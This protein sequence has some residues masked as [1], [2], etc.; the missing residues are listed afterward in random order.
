VLP[1]SKRPYRNQEASE[2]INTD[3]I[4]VIAARTDGPIAA[5]EARTVVYNGPKPK[6]SSNPPAT[7]AASTVTIPK[8]APLPKLEKTNLRG[9]VRPVRD[10]ERTMLRPMSSIGTASSRPSPAT[11]IATPYTSANPTPF[12]MSSPAAG[13]EALTAHDSIRP[14][15]ISKDTDSLPLGTVITQKTKLGPRKPGMSW[16]AALMAVGVFLGL[17]TAVI[18]RGDADALIEATASFV[19]PSHSAARPSV[20]QAGQ[21]AA[22][23]A[24]L[25]VASPK[26]E[27]PIIQIT[28]PEPPPA[29]TPAT[30][31]PVV[32]SPIVNQLPVTSVPL[33]TLPKTKGAASAHPAQAKVAAPAPVAAQ[34]KAQKQDKPE[35]SSGGAQ[36]LSKRADEE[37]EGVMRAIGR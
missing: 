15:S 16:A 4:Q 7:L 1:F 26:H 8:P 6:K 34:P 24:I 27:V 25:P 29:A 12:S 2:L 20:G 22:G 30:V 9:L 13:R 19:D 21:A 33:N 17:V 32:A 28:P 14:V 37:L 35:G 5:D 23:A 18:A 11:G 3:E 10:D 36:G 31:T